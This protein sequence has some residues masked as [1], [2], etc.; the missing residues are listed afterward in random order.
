MDQDSSSDKSGLREFSQLI[1]IQERLLVGLQAVLDELHAPTTLNLLRALKKKTG[2]MVGDE[3][4]DITGAVEKAIRDL[5]VFEA[6]L[7][8][9][10]LTGREEIK[11]DGISNLPPSMARFLA[12]RAQFPGFSHTVAQDP[13]RGWVIRWKEYTSHGTVRGYGQIYER[14]YAWLED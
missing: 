8:R 2:R 10:L 12:E 5:K 14:P 3:V 6:D 4:G 11:V 9:E 1:R 7:Q 13:V